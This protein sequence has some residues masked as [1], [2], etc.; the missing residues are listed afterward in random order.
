MAWPSPSAHHLR[1]IGTGLMEAH[2]WSAWEAAE[3]AARLDSQ[4]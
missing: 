2:R 1:L 3:I 4:G